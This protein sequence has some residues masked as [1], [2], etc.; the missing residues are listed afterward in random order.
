MELIISDT[1]SLILLTKIKI[2][3]NVLEVYEIIIPNKVY[4]EIIAGKEKIHTDA[5]E[6]EDLINNNIIKIKEPNIEAVNY[7][8]NNFKLDAGELYAIAL[9]RQLDQRVLID[10]KKGINTCK[11][12]NIKYFNVLGLLELLFISNI[13]DEKKI[14]NALELLSI[15]AWYKPNELELFKNKIKNM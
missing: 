1:S 15:H 11:A 9:A 8:E 12:L 14:L 3:N 7:L 10:D 6:I 13:I 5:F 4:L 2:I